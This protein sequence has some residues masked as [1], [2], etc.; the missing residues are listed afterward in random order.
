MS[1]ATHGLSLRFF[2]CTFTQVVT[3]PFSGLP[4]INLLRGIPCSMDV[5]SAGC[6]S[7][8]S[9][10]PRFFTGYTDRM[11]FKERTINTLVSTHSLICTRGVAVILLFHL[12][13]ALCSFGE[14]LSIQ[15][16]R[17]SL[18][19]FFMPK[20]I[21]KP[22]DLNRQDSVILFYFTYVNMWRT[23]PPFW[24]QTVF[25]RLHFSSENS[26]LVM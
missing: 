9:Y 11:S 26:F 5:K 23:L 24:L 8:P 14:E 4:T 20:E 21:N 3:K 19:D 13:D 17:S 25:W 16:E 6:P 10:V 12:K 2:F 22:N 1:P 15:R 7:P 18:R